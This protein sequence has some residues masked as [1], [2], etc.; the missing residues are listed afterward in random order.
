MNDYLL[1]MR[2]I[3]KTFPGVLALD[4]V[5]LSLAEGEVLALLGEN[6]AGKSTLIKVL[7]G[8]YPADS[9][10][11]FIEGNSAQIKS[12]LDAWHQ[13]VSI[14]YQEFNLIPDL[15][16]RENIFLGKEITRRGFIDSDGERDKTKSLFERIGLDLDPDRAC[17]ELTVAQQ[18]TVEIAKALSFQN[19]IIVMDE[20]Y[21]PFRRFHLI[22]D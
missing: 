7:G 22:D 12:P 5:S 15:T 13:G 6:G 3:V 14:I 8:A 9:G 10:E 20:P 2:N 11:I 1:E 16:V 18:Q 21:Q 19:K 4:E 17:S